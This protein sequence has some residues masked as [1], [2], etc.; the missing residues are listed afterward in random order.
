VTLP[1]TAAPR[2]VSA[3]VPYTTVGGALALRTWL[4]PAHAELDRV[5]ATPDALVL[6]ATLHGTPATATQVVVQPPGGEPVAFDVSGTQF[7]CTV[8]YADLP[9]HPGTWHLR[10]RASDGALIPLGRLAGDNVDRK[11]TDAFP[12]RSCG[13]LTVRPVF[14]P[15]NNLTLHVKAP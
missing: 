4:R 3:W 10:V 14:A 9:E 13:N 15:S 6:D 2:E 1:L 7:S 5:H 12:A 11:R 8:P